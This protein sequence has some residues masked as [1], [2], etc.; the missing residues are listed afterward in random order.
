VE[1]FSRMSLVP[2]RSLP[3]FSHGLM[4]TENVPP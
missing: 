4:D 1:W 2:G 3:D